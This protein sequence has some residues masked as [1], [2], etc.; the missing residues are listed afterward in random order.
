M[1]QYKQY[2]VLA[3]CVCDYCGAEFQKPSSELL[4]NEKLNRHNFCSRS[5]AGKYRQSL[6][7]PLSDSQ[8]ENRKNFS[9]YSAN[10]KDEYTPY[11]ETLHR[12]KRRF[13]DVDITLQDL[14]D[15]WEKQKG[16]CAYTNIKLLLPIGNNHP[17][18]RYQASLDR[19]DPTKGYIKDNIQFVAAPI[20]YMKT[21]MSDQVFKSYLKEIVSA[22]TENQTISSSPFSKEE[23][24]AQAGN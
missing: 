14:K 6:N 23:Q 19:I 24:D 1:E 15:L 16:R 11:R 22:F 10:R 4:R 20:N 9:K 8:I 13:K 7:L 2:R 5:C 18:I 3:N 17:D 21:T 12:T